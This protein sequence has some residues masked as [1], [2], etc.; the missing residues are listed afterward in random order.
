M[1]LTP[2]HFFFS[3]W[4][5]LTFFLY[6]SIYP[7]TCSS[8][9]LETSLLRTPNSS[10]FQE[11]HLLAPCSPVHC[12]GARKPATGTKYLLNGKSVAKKKGASDCMSVFWA[13]TI[14]TLTSRLAGSLLNSPLTMEGRQAEDKAKRS[15]PSM[16]IWSPSRKLAHKQLPSEEVLVC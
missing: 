8:K 3:G 5:V 10:V 15:C 12:G 11:L 2:S 16:Q 13:G 6:S 1:D 9:G 4:V 7:K 14:L